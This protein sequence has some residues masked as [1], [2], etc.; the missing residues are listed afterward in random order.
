[1]RGREGVFEVL[2][3]D[4]D[5]QDVITRDGSALEIK[6]VA[7]QKGMR[8]LLDAGILKIFEGKTS[9]EELNRV[10]VPEAVC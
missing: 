9:V 8:T 4:N 1:M 3:V 7:A 10:I 2:K 5:I 6:K